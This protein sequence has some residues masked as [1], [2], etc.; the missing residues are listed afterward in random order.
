MF[1]SALFRYR[2][3]NHG[4]D[5]SYEAHEQAKRQLFESY[6][7]LFSILCVLLI[8]ISYFIRIKSMVGVQTNHGE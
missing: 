1:Q 5:I 4:I 7:L 2:E 8:I 6:F 3:T